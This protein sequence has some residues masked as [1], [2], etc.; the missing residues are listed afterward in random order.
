MKWSWLLATSI[1]LIFVY[2]KTSTAETAEFRTVVSRNDQMI[3]GEFHLDLEMKIASGTSPRTLNSITVE[4]TYGS[5]L[6]EWS[7]AFPGTNWFVSGDGYTRVVDKLSGR[8]KVTITGG[9][10]GTS[11]PGDPPGWDVMTAFQRVVTL[12]WTIHTAS[13]VNV[14]IDDG[15]DAAA[16][17]ENLHND[18]QGNV[19]DWAVTNQ[20]LGDISLPVELA[21]FESIAENGLV[22]LKWLTESEVN[23]LGFEIYRAPEKEADYILLSGYKTNPDLAGQGNSSTR[24]EY[25]YN[26]KSVKP[27]TTYWYKLADLDFSGV[28]TFHNPISVTTAKA[29][30]TG[31]K[32]KPNY[33]NPFNPT[34]TISFDIPRTNTELVDT[35]L[36]IYNT[37]G[38]VTKT[39][40]QDKLNAG[41]Y[42]V[43]WDGTTDGG[44]YAPSGIYFVVFSAN[45]FS[46]TGKLI[47]LK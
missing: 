16:Y 14:S 1:M 45:E 9:G 20:D 40:Y 41:S 29:L 11:G 31:F 33:P 32:L 6:D 42:E 23:N 15:T 18:P 8:Y 17:F 46:Q 3:G 26:D 37:L 2:T 44:N 36:I 35:Q 4:I 5:E 7:T 34:T 27:E 21:S 39:L 12:R 22:T 30:P 47:L 10:V 43:Q 38:Q 13:T 28:K 24:H 19:V 25:S